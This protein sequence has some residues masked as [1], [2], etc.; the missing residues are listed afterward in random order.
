MA[1]PTAMPTDAAP[2]TAPH[3]A[4][5]T[6]TPR[7]MLTLTQWLSPAFPVGAFAYSHGLEAAVQSGS[8]TDADSFAAWLDGVLRFGAGRNDAILVR[9]S[10]ETGDP[11]PLD[12]LNRAL[13]PA[14]TRALETEQMGASLCDT[15]AEVWTE[16]P[17]D[18]T[19]PVALGQASR[20]LGMPITLVVQMMLHAFAANLVSAAI[21]LVPLGQTEGQ[22][23]L[24]ACGATC[25][26]IAEATVSARRGDLHSAPLV[27]DLHAMQHDTL[28]SR[29]FRS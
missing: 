1:A 25:L 3:K 28:Y 24:D 12:A 7:Q 17:R 4:A 2:A 23:L 11:R 15:V 13:Q 14:D 5:G 22:K 10:A 18:L 16:I 29:I 26:D 27:S 8:V 21:R 9:L 6:L 20:A 19:F